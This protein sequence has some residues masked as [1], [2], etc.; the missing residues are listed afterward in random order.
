MNGERIAVLGGDTREA[1][2]AG[3]LRERGYEVALYGVTPGSQESA[4]ITPAASAQ[5]AVRGACWVVCPSPGLGD[6]DVVYAPTSPEPIVLDAALMS[7]S[8]ASAGGMVM[9]RATPGV[10]A[11]AETLRIPIFEMKDDR[12]LAA[13]NARSVAEA[14]VAIL[15]EK[16]VRILPEH[17]ILVI[18][19]GATGAALS[20]ALLGLSCEVGVV[21]RREESLA[22]A[23]AIGARSVPFSDRVVAMAEADIVVNTVPSV[24]A[25]PPEAYSALQR[26]VVVDIASPPG[27]AD[28]EAAS[29][30]G[31]NLTWARGLAGGRAP[32]SAGDAQLA[33]ILRSI[34]AR[35]AS[36]PP[37]QQRAEV[38]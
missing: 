20:R 24:D 33:F 26:A 17:R 13:S 22:E 7:S 32:H 37:E 2:I 5:E 31:V 3:Q 27:G 28:H 35:T 8:S 21:A 11:A 1:Y 34:D 23:A 4:S 30:A 29:A 19:Y 6:G 18:G 36:A 10:R 14:L 38:P 15:V 9:G 16:T 12:M 25:V